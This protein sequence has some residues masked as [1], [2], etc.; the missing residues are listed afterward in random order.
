MDTRIRVFSW[1]QQIFRFFPFSREMKKG[2]NEDNGL[3]ETR[4]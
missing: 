3:C 4:K 1:N 2:E